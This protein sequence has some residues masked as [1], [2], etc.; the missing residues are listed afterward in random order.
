MVGL[1]TEDLPPKTLQQ[2]AGIIYRRQMGECAECHD[3][4]AVDEMSLFK[5]SKDVA[6]TVNTVKLICERCG[7]KFQA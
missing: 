4:L 6:T 3:K 2:F 7:G 1:R 5:A